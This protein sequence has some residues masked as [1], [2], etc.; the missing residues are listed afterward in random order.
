MRTGNEPESEC[1]GSKGER[2][3]DGYPRGIPLNGNRLKRFRKVR[4]LT[5]VGLGQ[6]A[7]CTSRTVSN[8]ERG[9]P[10]APSVL[11]A[12]ASALGVKASAL[13]SSD[14]K[15]RRP[16]DELLDRVNLLIETI[17]QESSRFVA[18]YAKRYRDRVLADESSSTARQ[19]LFRQSQKRVD[20]KSDCRRCAAAVEFWLPQ[21]KYIHEFENWRKSAQKAYAHFQEFVHK[22]V[23][24]SPGNSRIIEDDVECARRI[25]L[26]EVKKIR[27][28]LARAL[29]NAPLGTGR[30]SRRRGKS[31]V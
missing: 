24:S 14:G 2:Y 27:R 9:R 28:T 30:P 1:M 18:L 22:A 23:I 7:G 8:A 6:R 20:R 25:M 26:G 13:V 4:G 15:R 5:Q 12:L 3:R 31:A 16:S 19:K 21:S 17:S 10:V 11:R 29:R